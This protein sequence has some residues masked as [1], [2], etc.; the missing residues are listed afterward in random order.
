[1]THGGGPRRA[2]LPRRTRREFRRR[3][4]NGATVPDAQHAFPRAGCYR[5]ACRVQGDEGEREVEA[6]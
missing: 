6:E 2:H 4:K 3:G 5:V 1:M